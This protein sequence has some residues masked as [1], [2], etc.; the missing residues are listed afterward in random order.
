MQLTEPST[1]VF[2]DCTH[3]RPNQHMISGVE[4]ILLAVLSSFNRSGVTMEL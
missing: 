2:Y 3:P 1:D 4:N